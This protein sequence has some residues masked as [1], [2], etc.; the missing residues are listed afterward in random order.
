VHLKLTQSNVTSNFVMR[1]PLYLEL[2]DGEVARMFSVVIHGNDTVDQTIP[3]N[4]LSSPAKTMLLNYNSDVL[5]DSV[6]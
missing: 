1:V 4:K 6:N 2:K 3:L 5:C